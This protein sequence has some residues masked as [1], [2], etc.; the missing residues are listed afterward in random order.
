M[1][2]TIRHAEPEDAEQIAT[3]HIAAWRTAYR[4]VINDAFLDSNEFA[5]SRHNGWQRR[6]HEGGAEGADPLD[7]LFVP[8]LN[9]R[10]VGFGHVGAGSSG[11]GE[12]YGFYVHPDA[13]GSGAGPALIDRCHAALATRFST[14]EVWVLSDNP[15][16]RRFYERQGWS[17]GEGESLIED[18][19][20]GPKL[21]DAPPFDP[22]AEVQY[23]RQL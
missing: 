7:E 22:V 15:R 20:T 16:A 11:A 4:G 23:R 2:I 17:C 12:L 14:A 21:P 1:T 10:V 6:L 8:V 3:A 9:G 19:W 18:I 5:Q 13:W